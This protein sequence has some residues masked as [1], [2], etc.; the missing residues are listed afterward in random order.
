METRMT[1]DGGFLCLLFGI[2]GIRTYTES[3]MAFTYKGGAVTIRGSALFCRTFL[4]KTVQISGFIEE[5]CMER[6]G[7]K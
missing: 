4:N 1:A 6:Q 3:E 5:I 7:R 2:R